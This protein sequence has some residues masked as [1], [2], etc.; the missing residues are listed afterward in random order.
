MHQ[1]PF[2]GGGDFRTTYAGADTVIFRPSPGGARAAAD[3]RRSCCSAFAAALVSANTG[4]RILIRIGL[5]WAD[6]AGGF[7]PH[8]HVG[9]FKGQISNRK[10]GTVLRPRVAFHLGLPY[11]HERDAGAGGSSRFRLRPGHGMSGS[12]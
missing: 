3:S 6:F 2:S 4:L 7:G 10:R 9:W 11:E 1:K 12:C 8:I 5:P